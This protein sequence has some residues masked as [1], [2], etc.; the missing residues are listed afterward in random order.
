MPIYEYQCRKCDK[1][2]EHLVRSQ[3]EK[4]PRCPSCG[5]ANPAKQLSV[6]SAAAKAAD[7]PSCAASK[8]SR[9]SCASGKCPMSALG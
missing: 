3:A 7:L 8:C 6:F 4:P 9:D 1:R 5:A 2:F